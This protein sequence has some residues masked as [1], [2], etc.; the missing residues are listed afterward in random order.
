LL[1]EN[2]SRFA[3]SVAVIDPTAPIMNT[4]PHDPRPGPPGFFDTFPPVSHVG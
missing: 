2:V 3:G 4:S 1:L